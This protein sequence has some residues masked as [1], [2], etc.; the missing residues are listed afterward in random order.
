MA[1]DRNNPQPC[2]EEDK[3][4]YPK[5][6][7]PAPPDSV[8]TAKPDA[9]TTATDDDGLDAL[10][11]TARHPCTQ[12]EGRDEEDTRNGRPSDRGVDVGR[13]VEALGGER[14]T[15]QKRQQHRRFEPE[16]VLRCDGADDRFA[17]TR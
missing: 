3:K 14:G 7:M 2:S 8:V 5:G 12:V 9:G 6:Q 13:K 10:R 17:A 4:K 16:H 15:R 1:S 11:I